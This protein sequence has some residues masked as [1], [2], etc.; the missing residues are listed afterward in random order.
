MHADEGRQDR[1]RDGKGDDEARPDAAHENQQYQCDQD[2]SD[3]QG[4]S[5]RSDGGLDETFLLVIRYQPDPFRK[6]FVDLRQ[7]LLDGG[8]HR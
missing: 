7:F 6:N 5:D 3:Q 8:N 2:D 1:K 4:L